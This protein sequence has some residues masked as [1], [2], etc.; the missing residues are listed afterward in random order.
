MSSCTRA[1]LLEE[2]THT[3]TTAASGRKSAKNA[4]TAWGVI[5]TVLRCGP[6]RVKA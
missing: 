5:P 4:L 1:Q 3:L 6:A 2:C